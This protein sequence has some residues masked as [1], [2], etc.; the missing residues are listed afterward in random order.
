MKNLL[1]RIKS[2]QTSK[3]QKFALATVL[4]LLGV[5]LIRSSGLEFVSWRIRAAGFLLFSIIA[6]IFALKDEDFSGVEWVMLPILPVFFAVGAALVYPLL[7]VRMDSFLGVTLRP[8]S[9][10]ILGVIIKA[11]FLSMFVIGYYASLLT[12]N[13]FNVAAVKGIQLL[14]VAHSIGFLVT[15]ATGLFFFVVISS[16]H[17]SS[18]Q[19]FLA[20]FVVSFPLALYSF[21]SINLEDKIGEEVRNFSF[22]SALVMAETA[23]VL[24]F[25]PLAVSMFAI[26]MTALFYELLGIIQFH[27][28]EKLNLRIVNEFVVVAV[29]VFLLTIFTTVWG[30]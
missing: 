8:D 9:S 24:S 11:L 5:I 1:E 27:L 29:V 10:F 16:L 2:F 17:L 18:F 3:R 13:I 28:G 14:R 4:L 19:N 6:T 25:W 7:P 15:I 26:F 20:V 12:S 30:A 22:I 21:W 23:W